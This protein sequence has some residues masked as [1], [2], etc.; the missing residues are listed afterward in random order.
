MQALALTILQITGI[1]CITSLRARAA[2]AGPIIVRP[3]GPSQGIDALLPEP[4]R[5][6]LRAGKRQALGRGLDGL[7]G[8]TRLGP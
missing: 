6:K 4:K 8:Q 5:I 2:P 1:L 7:L 3:S